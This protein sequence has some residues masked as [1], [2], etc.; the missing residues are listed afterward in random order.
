M[1]SPRSFTIFFHRWLNFYILLYY[2][3]SIILGGVSRRHYRILKTEEEFLFNLAPF[4]S[5]FVILACCHPLIIICDCG[6]SFHLSGAIQES[7]Q[8]DY[9][10]S[11][12]SGF[13]SFLAFSYH[14]PI[15]L[16][17]HSSILLSARDL[18]ILM[19]LNPLKYPDLFSNS[20]R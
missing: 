4:S 11:I 3:A 5:R 2:G 18:F 17:H 6:N 8:F 9:P 20:Y 16:V 7:S 19:Y 1:S 10:E 14:P 12:I 13:F 15:L